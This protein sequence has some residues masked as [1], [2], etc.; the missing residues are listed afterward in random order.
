MTASALIL[1]AR[2][3]FGRAA[4]LAFRDSGWEVHAV[5]R[6]DASPVPGV[7]AHA[8]DASDPD[9][10]AR[11]AAGRDLIV[12]AANTPYPDW[13][14]T[15][16]ALTR[17]VLA[18][19]EASGA[20]V[21]IPGNVYVFGAGMPER[22]GPDTPH[23]PTTRKGRIRAEME[24][25]FRAAADRGVRTIVLRAGD[26]LDAEPT[27]NWFDAVLAKDLARGKL[28]Y[29]GRTDAVH[30]WAWLPDMA[31]A[32]VALAERRAA[33]PAYAD[34]PFPGL[35]L[36]GEALRAGLARAAGRD[37]RIAR[38][39]WWLLRLAAPFRP[40]WRELLEMRYLW[41]VPHRLDPA[42]LDRL[43]PDVPWTPGEEVLR[44]LVGQGSATSTQTTRWSDASA[45]TSAIASPGDGQ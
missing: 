20:T 35:A 22:L 9:A 7:I 41:D 31:R 15:V 45:T 3:R 43:L 30:A 32:A 4:S 23:R 28:T 44:R 37:I 26:F 42:S 17:A 36:T 33:L 38:F 8:A 16:P 13:P 14:R 18:A 6:G 11:L 2:G 24:A 1:G 5:A 27:G 12:H 40:M 29:P 10:L 39:P 34:I 19:A 21:L 25:A